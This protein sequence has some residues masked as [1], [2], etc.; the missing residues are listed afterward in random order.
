MLT[1]PAIVHWSAD[2][3]RTIRDTPTDDIGLGVHFAD[4]P[5]ADLAAAAAVD[6]TLRWLAD[7]RWEGV[8]YRLTVDGAATA[9]AAAALTPPA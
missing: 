8:D 2:A 3:W 1:S 5:A 4:I 7:D 9:E 6:F